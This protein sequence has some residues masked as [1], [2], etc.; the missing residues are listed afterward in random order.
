MKYD[1]NKNN[2]IINYTGVSFWKT[3]MEDDLEIHEIFRTVPLDILSFQLELLIQ[4]LEIGLDIT[5]AL[6]YLIVLIRLVAEGFD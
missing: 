5:Y 3:I 4:I 6:L 2:L 1:Q